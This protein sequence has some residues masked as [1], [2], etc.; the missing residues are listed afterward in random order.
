MSRRP[1]KETAVKWFGET[2]GAWVC[3]PADHIETP[4]KELCMLCEKPIEPTD[5]GLMVPYVPACGPVRGE[6]WHRECFL[7]SI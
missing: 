1:T 6:P 3:A 2:W 4:V 5:Q 7:R